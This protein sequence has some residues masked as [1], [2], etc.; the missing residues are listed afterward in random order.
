MNLERKRSAEQSRT[1]A[2]A[3]AIQR[4]MALRLCTH[5]RPLNE[6]VRNWN[7][8]G[9]SVPWFDPIG[10]GVDAKVLF[11]LQDP[12]KMADGVEGS[13]F[14]SHDNDDTAAPRVW[15][16]FRDAGISRELVVTWNIVPW[17]LN[18]KG[19][20]VIDMKNG[21]RMLELVLMQCTKLKH[22][23]LGGSKSQEAWCRYMDTDL[24]SRYSVSRC[25]HPTP[26]AVT[27]EVRK[28]SIQKALIAAKHTMSGKQFVIQ[29]DKNYQ[30]IL[31]QDTVAVWRQVF[32][33]QKSFGEH[34]FGQLS[35][36][37]FFA[38]LSP[39]LNSCAVIVNH[40][41]GN[42]LS[43]W[44]DFLTSDGEKANRDRDAEFEPPAEHSADERAKI[45]GRWGLGW[46][47]LFEAIDSLTAEDLSKIVTIR[48]VEHPVHAAVARQIDH[49]S[50][51]IG[52]IN[53][54][55]RQL[56]GTE[57]W[58]WFTIAPGGTKAFNKELMGE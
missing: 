52:Q 40:L 53:I 19:I 26:R 47:K 18:D 6:L 5:V 12:G 8:E 31:P 29:S 7:A 57:D 30:S 27:T 33:R 23:V 20:K 25:I 50:F 24:M 16:A 48:K 56:V 17:Y 13:G 28:N 32:E 21:C 49:Y 55:A 41:A 51:H 37:Q 9:M 11:L 44:T 39:G 42:M 34:A 14:I 38:V 2:S 10:G 36:E 3:D 1:L 43:R 15:E 22:V 45:M 58:Q 54:I 4:R 46:S 35:N